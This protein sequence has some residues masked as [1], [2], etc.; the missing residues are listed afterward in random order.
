M[1]PAV[2]RLAT[3]L[4]YTAGLRRDELVRL[5]LADWDL[6]RG[7]L[8][9]EASKFGKSRLVALS[10]DAR[11]ELQCY[12]QRRLGWSAAAA[13]PLLG[14][15]PDTRRGYSGPGLGDGLRQLFR[16]AE[17]RDARGNRPRVHDLRPTYAV[18][19]LLREYR[20]GRDPQ[21]LLPTLATAMGQVSAASTAY[22]LTCLEPV[23]TVAAAQAVEPCGRCSERCQ[24]TR[25]PD[26]RTTALADA[27]RG[28]FTE[29][30]PRV[31]GL[32]RQTVLAYRD[33]L[34]LL[35]RYLAARHGRAATALDFPDLAPDA[36]L[37]FL[38]HLETDRGN[39]A[40]TRNARLAALHAVARNAAAHHPEHLALC[41]RILTIPFQRTDQRLVEYLDADELRALLQAPGAAAHGRRDYT[42]LL[43]LYNTGARVQQIHDLRP[44][45]R[46]LEP[47]W[48]ALL[49]D[50]GRSAADSDPLFRNRHGQPLT[51][52]GVR[53]ILNKHARVAAGTVHSL[54]GKR[55]HP[56]VLRHTAATHLLQA[57]VD[58]VT[59]SR[60]LGHANLTT[61]GR[62]L[63]VD[64][65]AKRTAVQQA[66]PAATA[67]TQTA[68][69]QTDTGV[70][71]W[72]ESL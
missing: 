26:A 33:A 31:R 5:T 15:G 4:L 55:L 20:C 23:L 43:A 35:L 53:Y 36:L 66:R 38:A 44:C 70:L 40:A 71:A 8:Q 54:A 57:Q 34:K 28:F 29:D 47:P 65:E 46:Q 24:G 41:Q 10:A 32:S 58:L 14:H 60:W 22:Y 17:V 72:L 18:H 6:A 27:L 62:Y 67:E 51:R 3:V 45:D 61:T 19:A 9:I 56:H 37:A 50:T 21:A 30:L 2:Y 63:A 39:S 1:R 16:A 25:M 52:F 42:L 12:S 59:I 13:D 11:H 7:T 68:T 49:D 69:W 64:L 48:Q